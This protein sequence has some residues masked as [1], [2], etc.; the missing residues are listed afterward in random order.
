MELIPKEPAAS[1]AVTGFG[2]RL[3][4]IFVWSVRPVRQGGKRSKPNPGE[5]SALT[6]VCNQ[7]GAWWRLASVRPCP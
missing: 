5:W 2:F 3:T 4:G 7:A 1:H 6:T